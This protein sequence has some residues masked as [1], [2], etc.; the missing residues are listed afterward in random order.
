MELAHCVE[1]PCAGW[2]A[3]LPLDRCSSVQEASKGH[4]AW[5]VASTQGTSL[6]AAVTFLEL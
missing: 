6:T 1:T 5:D 4:S 3:P 2:G